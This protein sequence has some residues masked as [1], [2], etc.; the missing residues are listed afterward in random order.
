MARY[1]TR[2]AAVVALG[3]TAL[4]APALTSAS[5]LGLGTF[6][7]VTSPAHTLTYHDAIGG[8]NHLNV[9]G[10]TSLDVTQVD[11][12]CI[13][14]IFDQQPDIQALATAVPVTAGSFSV[15]A[16]FPSTPGAQCRLMAVPNGVDATTDYLGSFTGPIVYT[17]AFGLTRDSGHVAYSYSGYAEEGDGT[18]LV[19]DA[20]T[21]GTE[22]LITIEAPQML[23]GPIMT[24]CLFALGSG[25]FGPSGPSTR[26]A[27]QIDGRNAYL[28]SGVHSFLIDS[29]TLTV[30]QSALT[31]KRSIAHD[32]NVTFTESA[33]LMRCS[34]S[35]AYPP[36]TTSCPSIVSTGVRYERIS[37]FERDGHQVKVRDS[38]T[39]TNHHA[40]SASL[41]YQAS[42][43]N[44]TA[45]STAEGRIGYTLP[46]HGSTFHA[47][48]PGQTLHGFG[49]KAGTLLIRSDLHALPT[50]GNADTMAGTW[51]RPPSK[52][53]FGTQPDEF[54]MQYAL[55]IAAKRP[56]FIGFAIS[57]RWR[58]ADVK[59]LAAAG[60][61]DFVV[62]PVITSPHHGA[63][64]HGTSITVKGSLTAGANGLPTKVRVNGH[65]ASITATSAT[66]ASYKVTFATSTGK[67][68]IKVVATDAVGNS[69]AS[70]TSVNG[71]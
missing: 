37:T 69:A 44:E 35:N 39:S 54:Q 32:G 58:T 45:S 55:N 61:A 70:S 43:E 50:D 26:S 38:F 53:F 71:I 49:S 65:A 23:A 41:Q 40:H 3:S 47:A 36:T 52:V 18:A 27:I 6:T 67:H 28:P 8:T 9:S 17:D 46:G 2:F 57:E 66:H 51:S 19:T 21:C 24:S 63:T 16:T 34:A 4:V 59:R 10:R 11:I 64:I 12:D 1:L 48:S 14:Y 25:N 5:A 22:T 15:N 29:R 56:A 30:T 62:K 7:K 31:V 13:T 60:A 42:L 20:G 33:L 68:K